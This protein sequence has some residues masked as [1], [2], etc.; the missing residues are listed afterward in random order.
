MNV[1]EATC[2]EDGLEEWTCSRCGEIQAVPIPATGHDFQVTDQKDPTCTEAGYKDMKCANCGEI[3]HQ[4]IAPL[5]HS[6]GEWETVTP[7]TTTT[8]GVKRRVCTRC[9]EEQLGTIP[10]LPHEH[11]Y[12]RPEVIA[13]TCEEQGYTKL[14]CECGKSIIDENSYVPWGTSGSSAGVRS[15]LPKRRA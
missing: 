6:G 7:A 12:T 15:P 10:K 9:Q 1:I 4:R 2:T 13:P 8:E 14:Y 3:R 5:G 11:H